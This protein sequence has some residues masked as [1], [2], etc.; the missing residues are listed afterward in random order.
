MDV[1]QDQ[2]K[3]MSVVLGKLAY[4]PKVEN[5][6]E[7]HDLERK[8]Y[9]AGLHEKL[10]AIAKFLGKNDWMAGSRLTY[11]DFSVYDSLDIHR[12]VFLPK[13]LNEF[14]TL[15]AYMKRVENL[16]GVK[17]YLNSDAFKPKPTFGPAAMFGNTA[18]YQPSE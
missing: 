7:I 2:V 4:P 1:I 18:D 15:L 11:V 9:V 8:E 3:D 17:E 13:H 12:H 14:P 5:R 6:K 16:K 10:A